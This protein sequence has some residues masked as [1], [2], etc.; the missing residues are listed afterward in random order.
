MLRA[1]LSL[2]ITNVVAGLALFLLVMTTRYHQQYH[3]ETWGK[4]I[5]GLL[6]ACPRNY[7]AYLGPHREVTGRQREGENG[8]GVLILM[9][10]TV[11]AHGFKGY[12]STGQLKT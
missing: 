1:G 5:K 8:P 3:Q 7:M 6:P 12:L 4:N 9:E 10:S 11:E 2:S